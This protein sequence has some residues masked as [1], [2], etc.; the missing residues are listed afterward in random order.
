[1]TK[2]PTYP[3]E[4]PW[5]AENVMEQRNRLGVAVAVVTVVVVVVVAVIAVVA[6]LV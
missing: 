4:H 1:V 6:D 2:V 3:P 5:Y